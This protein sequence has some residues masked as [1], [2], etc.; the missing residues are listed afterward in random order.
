MQ[1]MAPEPSRARGGKARGFE[2]VGVLYHV[3]GPPTPISNNPC[4]G[5]DE[6]PTVPLPHQRRAGPGDQLHK[7]AYDGSAKRVSALLSSGSFDID[8][9]GPIMGHT[10]LMIA[11]SFSH[12]HVVRILLAKGA[13]VSIVGGDGFTALHL[14]V[15]EGHLAVTKMLVEAGAELEVL[16]AD[17]S[18]PLYMAASDGHSE[19]MCVLVEAGANPNF[20]HFDG[21]T[22]LYLAAHHG[23]VNAVKKMLHAKANPLLAKKRPEPRKECVVPLDVAALMGHSEVVRELVQQVGI[24]GCGGASGGVQALHL[25]AMNRHLDILVMLTDAGVVDT[26]EVLIVAVRSALEASVKFLLRRKRGTSREKASYASFR[27][28]ETGWNPLFVAIGGL[29]RYSPSPRIVRLLVDAGADTA[30][31]VRFDDSSVS[32]SALE[33]TTRMLRCKKGAA[34]GKDFTEDQ[35][36][37]LEGIR[38]LL[39]RVEA[40]HATSWLWPGDIPSVVHTTAVEGSVGTKK[41][42]APLTRVLPLLR[43]RARR[44]RVLLAALCR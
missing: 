16:T 41:I 33:L 3:T 10:P 39:L 32:M 35:L 36:H 2:A 9:R 6:M 15:A 40:V 18:T 22:P 30:V 38:R 27:A 7:A 21:T 43:K 31:R 14:A 24:E 8:E 12:S 23:D 4:R 25:A 19:V 28:R 34:H 44:P 13:N 29:G 26:G 11:C 42:S 17:G 5:A 1:S 20:R 37:G